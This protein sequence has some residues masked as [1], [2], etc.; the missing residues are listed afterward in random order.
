MIPDE[1][2]RWDPGG[3]C[4]ADERHELDNAGFA[5]RVTALAAVFAAAGL[6]PGGV[7]AIMLPNRVELVTSMFA[8]LRLGAAVTPVNAALTAQE[9]RYRSM[10]RAPRW[11]S[12]TRR[13]RRSCARARTGS[14]G[15]PR[16]CPAVVPGLRLVVVI[17]GR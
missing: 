11:S 3:D 1:R 7:L 16:G 9:A 10:T 8:A 13:P 17:G 6:R 15:W 5:G 4:V 14:S 2:A 12:P